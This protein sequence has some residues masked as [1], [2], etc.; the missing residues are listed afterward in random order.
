MYFSGS[1]GSSGCGNADLVVDFCVRVL[2]LQPSSSSHVCISI[3]YVCECVSLCATLIGGG[4][5][6]D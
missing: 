6:R 1:S 5:A 3:F 4:V 2:N